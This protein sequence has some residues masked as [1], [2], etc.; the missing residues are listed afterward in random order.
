MITPP[1]FFEGDR[2]KIEIDFE[3]GE[4]YK[5]ILEE[6]QHLS[7]QHIGDLLRIKGYGSDAN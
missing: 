5:A 2:F 1:P 6:L 7:R 4:E 3:S